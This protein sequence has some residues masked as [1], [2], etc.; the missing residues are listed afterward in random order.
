M[1]GRVVLIAVLSVLPALAL[2]QAPA[3]TL[4]APGTGTENVTYAYAQVLRADPIY[5][6][7]RTRVPEQ[8][9]DPRCRVVQIERIERRLT[10][11]DVEYRYMGETYMSRVTYDPGSRLRIRVSVMPDDGGP[12]SRH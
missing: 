2:A 8:R 10:Y 6:T 3:P 9:C 5:E 12:G 4:P 11:Y 7:V 1:I